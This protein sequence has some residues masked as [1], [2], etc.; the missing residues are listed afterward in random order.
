MLA[1][2]CTAPPYRTFVSAY[3][4]HCHSLDHSVIP[5]APFASPG[6]APLIENHGNMRNINNSDTVPWNCRGAPRQLLLILRIT[7]TSARPGYTPVPRQN[8]RRGEGT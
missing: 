8:A 1:F 7:P 5:S 4:T 2:L 6:G 3:R